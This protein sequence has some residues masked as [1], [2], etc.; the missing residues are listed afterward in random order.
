MCE[1]TKQKN[2]MALHGGES[3]PHRGAAQNACNREETS[4][5]LAYCPG[6]AVSVRTSAQEAGLVRECNTAGRVYLVAKR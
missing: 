6:P 3:R 1:E 5:T 4:P 2:E